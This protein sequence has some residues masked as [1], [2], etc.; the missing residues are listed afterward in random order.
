MRR[1]PRGFARGAARLAQPGPGRPAAR[2]AAR[3]HRPHRAPRR[4]G[5]VRGD[6]AWPCGPHGRCPGVGHAGLRGRADRCRDRRRAVLGRH[7]DRDRAR[8]RHG[9]GVRMARGPD[10]RSG[11]RRL[12]PRMAE[13]AGGGGAL[14]R[15]R[16][17]VLAGGA[18][19][20]LGTAGLGLDWPLSGSIAALLGTAYGWGLLA[21][22]AIVAALIGLAA[23]DTW[24]LGPALRDSRPGAAGPAR[25]GRCGGP[26]R[27][28]GRRSR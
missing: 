21:E 28:R 27:S 11:A 7:G 18:A 19:G 23:L 22:A 25:P 6:E 15:L 12:P 26:S 2:A 14:A 5:A 4:R 24:R 16:Q 8:D 17:G 10:G 1:L 13:P 20:F 9:A 3:R